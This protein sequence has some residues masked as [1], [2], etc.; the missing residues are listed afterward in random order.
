MFTFQFPCPHPIL[1]LLFIKELQLQARELTKTRLKRIGVK[2][3]WMQGFGYFSSPH[4]C[5]SKPI[6]YTGISNFLSWIAVHAFLCCWITAFSLPRGGCR[7][8]FFGRCKSTVWK[9]QIFFHPIEIRTKEHGNQWSWKS[10]T[11]IK[12]WLCPLIL[13][14]V[15]SSWFRC[16]SI[17][18]SAIAACYGSCCSFFLQ[19]KDWLCDWETI[20]NTTWAEA[21][22]FLWKKLMNLYFLVNNNNN[23]QNSFLKYSFVYRTWKKAIVMLFPRDH[24]NKVLC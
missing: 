3:K 17:K 14:V 10:V 24:I 23:K 5:G 1:P 22:P 6:V 20:H 2:C 12:N 7:H 21:E 11:G 16:F 8:I 9:V 19:T 15:P 18:H 13:S 4:S